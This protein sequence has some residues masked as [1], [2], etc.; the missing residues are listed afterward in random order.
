MLALKV[1]LLLLPTVDGNYTCFF[2]KIDLSNGQFLSDILI[3]MFMHFSLISSS[4][5]IKVISSQISPPSMPSLRNSVLKNVWDLEQLLSCVSMLG[6]DRGGKPP[7]WAFLRPPTVAT[8]LR[9][10]GPVGG[11]ESRISTRT[12]MVMSKRSRPQ[13]CILYFYQ[14]FFFFSFC[15]FSL[16]P[17]FTSYVILAL[18]SRTCLR[19]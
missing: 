5:C 7:S 13:V 16:Y 10:R 3:T 9:T 15:Y 14:V 6:L 1:V 18:Q 8:I 4:M 11:H 12:V 17:L 19:A 2:I